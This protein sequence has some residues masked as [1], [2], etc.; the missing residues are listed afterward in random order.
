[1][2]IIF[3]FRDQEVGGSNPLAPT[4]SFKKLQATE[5]ADQVQESK[6]GSLRGLIFE[7]KE[8]PDSRITDRVRLFPRS[9]TCE[10]SDP[11]DGGL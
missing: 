11:A 4:N 7:S 3:T 9:L 1:M 8:F 10:P 6:F 2:F 5:L